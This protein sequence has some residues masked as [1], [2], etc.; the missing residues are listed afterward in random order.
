LAAP[1]SASRSKYKTA[2]SWLP[3]KNLPK[4]MYIRNMVC[5][6]VRKRKQVACTGRPPLDKANRLPRTS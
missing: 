4:R 2:A 5:P 1:I 6:E 3:E